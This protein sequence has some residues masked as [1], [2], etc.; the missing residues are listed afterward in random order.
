M[1]LHVQKASGIGTEHQQVSMLGAPT[2][3]ERKTTTPPLGTSHSQK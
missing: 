3:R 1:N 2:Y